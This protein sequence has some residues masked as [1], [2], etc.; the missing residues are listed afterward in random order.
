M[1]NRPFFAAPTAL[2]LAAL[3]A[4]SAAP[5][6]VHALGVGRLSVQSALGE[7]MRAEIDITNLSAEE[8][9]SLQVRV[10]APEAYRTAGVDYNAVLASTQAVVARRAD[11]RAV[12]RLSSDRAVQEPFVE[13]ILELSWSSGRLVREF[14]LLFDPPGSRYAPPAQAAAPV[15]AAAPPAPPAAPPAPTRPAP[16]V[17][18]AVAQAP[19]APRAPAAAAMP[20]PAA[21][22][23]QAG[24]AAQPPATAL[25]PGARL[26][27]GEPAPMAPGAGAGKSC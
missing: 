17:A 10:A 4:L 23:P 7:G 8:A 6:D 25:R 24:R 11:G 16:A 2:A 15:M 27:A 1:K 18:P 9:A 14:T 12:L 13:V 20:A 3:A 26:A 19:A 21:P 22:A 5:S